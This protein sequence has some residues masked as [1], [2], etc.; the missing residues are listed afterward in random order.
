MA[1]E[2]KKIVRMFKDKD[3]QESFGEW[4]VEL[5][6]RIKEKPEDLVWFF[7]RRRLLEKWRREVKELEKLNDE[8][9]WNLVLKTAEEEAKPIRRSPEALLRMARQNE[10]K[11]RRIEAKLKKLG[12]I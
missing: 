1:S 10:K 4:I 12:V 7:E 6:E 2:V 9:L 11:F 5:A 3:V 8:E